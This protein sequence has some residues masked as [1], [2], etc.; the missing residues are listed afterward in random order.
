MTSPTMQ[1]YVDITTSSVYH[2]MHAIEKF[3][4]DNKDFKKQLRECECEQHL[5][6]PFSE[7]WHSTLARG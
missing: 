5:S 2:Y 6:L 3:I 1:S 7:Q 4:R